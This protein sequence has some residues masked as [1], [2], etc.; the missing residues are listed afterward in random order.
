MGKRK[1]TKKIGRNEACPC[2]SGRK[3]KKCCLNRDRD[4]ARLRSEASP[5]GSGYPSG[6]SPAVPALAQ[7]APTTGNLER[8]ASSPARQGPSIS[9]YVIARIFEESEEFAELQRA[10]PR[11][12]ARFWT[13]GKVAA[14][15]TAEIISRLREIGVDGSRAAFVPLTD[16]TTSAW[17]VSGVWRELL[18]RARGGPLPRH[19]DDFL[20]LAA[21]ELW[22]RTCPARPSQEMLD[23]WMQEGYRL[24]MDR[25]LEQACDLWQ[26]V[27]EVIRERLTPQMR[28]CED[29]AVVF[30][31]RQCIENWLQDFQLEL[32]NAA[33]KYP[34]YAAR[35]VALAEEVLAHFPDQ[36]GLF[37]INFRSDLGEALFLADRAD[38]GER[39]LLQLIDDHPNNPDGYAMLA[40][41][42]GQGLR[43]GDPPVDRERAIAV[44]ESALARP[45]ENASMWDLQSRLED[46][47]EPVESL[48]GDDVG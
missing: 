26:R 25:H 18:R 44:L 20:G 27:W 35:A 37:T 11:D 42:L 33:V 48:A 12:A 17:D 22:K 1:K 38:E 32:R 14:L 5:S 10:E 9:P 30:D 29:A 24:W 4:E 36:G 47:R 15:E 45:V 19:D 46:L 31:G 23:D 16:G 43:P 8:L 13:I 39:A 40:D 7:A 2:G 21:C 28:T 3:Y 34:A 41:M 6:H